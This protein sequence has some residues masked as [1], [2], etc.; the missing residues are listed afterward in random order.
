MFKLRIAEKFR[1]VVRFHAHGCRE[2]LHA[3]TAYS[4]QAT[5]QQIRAGVMLPALNHEYC[6]AAPKASKEA[7]N[8]V[9]GRTDAS[10]FR[11]V[12]MKDQKDVF[13]HRT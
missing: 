5:P 6:Q 1:R 3:G 10:G 13:W 4:F 7:M 12:E 9:T 11:P 2:I 8:P